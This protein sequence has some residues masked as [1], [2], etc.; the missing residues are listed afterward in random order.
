MY[1]LKIL[2][3]AIVPCTYKKSINV[4]ICH[5]ETNILKYSLILILQ[6]SIYENYDKKQKKKK[7]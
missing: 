5:M 2:I 4:F 7:K 3:N 6:Y 1:I